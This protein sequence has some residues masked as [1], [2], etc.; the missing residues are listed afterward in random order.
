MALTF[1]LTGL[2][3]AAFSKEKVE[4]IALDQYRIKA[5]FY[6]VYG[7]AGIWMILYLTIFGWP[8]IVVSASIFILFLVLYL[9]IFGVIKRNFRIQFE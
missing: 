4:P 1:L 2:L 5:L 9:I 7:T 6:S 3:F 8:M